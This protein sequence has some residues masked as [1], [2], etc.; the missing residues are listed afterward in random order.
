MRTPLN[1][2]V[3]RLS[4]A[5]LDAH[6]P[7]VNFDWD[8]DDLSDPVINVCAKIPASISQDIDEICNLLSMPKRRFIQETFL[9]AIDAAWDCIRREG[10]MDLP[11]V[12]AAAQASTA[13]AEL[14][15]RIACAAE[16][17]KKLFESTE[18]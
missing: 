3:T 7:E 4:L 11:E 18:E 9:E 16:F 2:L 14:R 1:A 17:H 6:A 8:N 5:Y 12:Q 13:R 10:L 15:A